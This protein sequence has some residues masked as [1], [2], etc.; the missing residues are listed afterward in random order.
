MTDKRPFWREPAMW[1]VIGLPLASVVAGVGLVVTA[2]R[3]GGADVVTDDVRRVAQI[4]TAD[5]GPDERAAQLGLSAVVSLHEGYVDVIPTT[6]EFVRNAPLRLTLA[7]PAQAAE[8][9][10]V[11]L[12]PGSLGWRAQADV[13]GSH[14]WLLQLAPADGHWRLRARLPRQQRAARLAPSLQAP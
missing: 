5:L 9:R 2:V 11:D 12:L 7:H 10:H 8:D 1:L 3:S 14:D 4:Q 6:G 13:D